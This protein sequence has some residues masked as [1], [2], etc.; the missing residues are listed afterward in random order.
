MVTEILK[1]IKGFKDNT[2][3]ISHVG[4]PLPRR[5][6]SEKKDFK[7]RGSVEEIQHLTNRS[8]KKGEQS[9]QQEEAVEETI[10]DQFP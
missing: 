3:E 4:A 6:R 2:E 5:S 9:S 1:S 8:S 7:L 10:E